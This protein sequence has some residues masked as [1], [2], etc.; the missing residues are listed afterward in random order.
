MELICRF[1]T[2]TGPNHVKKKSPRKPSKLSGVKEKGTK[3]SLY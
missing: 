1:G 2:D 3:R